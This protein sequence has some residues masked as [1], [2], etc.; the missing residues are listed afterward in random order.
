MLFLKYC[1]EL[2][3]RI[4]GDIMELKKKLPAHYK[5]YFDN[6]LKLDPEEILNCK[7]YID[8]QKLLSVSE[9]THILYYVSLQFNGPFRGKNNWFYLEDTQQ[10][11]RKESSVFYT[12]LEKHK[13]KDKC[14]I[15]IKNTVDLNNYTKTEKAEYR[16]LIRDVSDIQYFSEEISL[17]SIIVQTIQLEESD[18]LYATVDESEADIWIELQKSL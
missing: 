10:W 18:D 13:I 3:F 9:L 4:R 14:Y 11:I 15:C 6:L 1:T 16:K 17:V 2:F 8:I 5:K 12:I 7:T